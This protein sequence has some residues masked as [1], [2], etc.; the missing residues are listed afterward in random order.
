MN[1]RQNSK[2][3]LV[4]CPNIIKFYYNGIN[5]VHIMDQKLQVINCKSKYRFYLSIFFDLM[6][7]S[8]I[9]SHIFYIKLGNDILLLNFEIVVA[10]ALIGRYSNRNRSFSSTRPN[11]RKSNEPS[12]TREVTT[13]MPEFQ[14]KQM[15][16]HY[17]K[18]ESSDLK[19]FVSCQACGLYV[20]ITILL[21]IIYP[22]FILLCLLCGRICL[23]I[24]NLTKKMHRFSCSDS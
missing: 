22:L 7:V 15:R 14:C 8:H 11:K 18:N 24:L 5:G 6:D 17:C 20:C 23:R 1:I 13:C 10:T 21:L 3:V 9:N 19:L 4:S 16:W 2:N 12:L